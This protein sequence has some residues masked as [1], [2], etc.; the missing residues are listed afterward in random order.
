MDLFY[1]QL[2]LRVLLFLRERIDVRD[3]IVKA[4]SLNRSQRPIEQAPA[5]GERLY[6]GPPRPAHSISG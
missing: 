6:N 1:A 4:I 5:P 2:A 3:I